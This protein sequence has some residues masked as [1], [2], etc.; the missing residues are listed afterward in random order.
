MDRHCYLDLYLIDLVLLIHLLYGYEYN[1]ALPSTKFRR[2]IGLWANLPIGPKGDFINVYKK[3]MPE[4]ANAITTE[5]GS[6][7]TLSTKAQVPS[8]LGHLIQ[9]KKTLENFN[10][11]KEIKKLSYSIQDETL[12]KYVLEDFLEKIQIGYLNAIL[13][14]IAKE[15]RHQELD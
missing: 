5:M 9:A 14:K 2:N 4:L 12:K 6:P 8:G 7:I 1:L 10:F 11:E 13:D 15:L 3:R